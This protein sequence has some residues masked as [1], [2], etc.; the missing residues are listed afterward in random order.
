MH[1]AHAGHGRG[2]F[3]Q[4]LESAYRF[5]LGSVAGGK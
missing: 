2:V 5:A 4:I 1:E 3:I